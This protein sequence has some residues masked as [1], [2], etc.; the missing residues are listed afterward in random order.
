MY[1]HPLSLPVAIPFCVSDFLRAAR[2]AGVDG[3]LVVDLPPEED[4]ELCLPAC[5]AGLNWIRL[6]TPTTDARR[7]PRV[8]SNT[9]WFVYYVSILGI[10]G[11][12]SAEA[13]AVRAAVAQLRRHTDLPVAVGFGIRK[14]GRAHV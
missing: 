4:A 5:E 8:L 6:A 7:L 14:I 12:R 3:L 1:V 11:T 10:T 13:E 2:D 9:S